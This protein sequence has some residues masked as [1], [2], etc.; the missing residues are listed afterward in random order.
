MTLSQYKNKKLK[1]LRKKFRTFTGE[2][3]GRSVINYLNRTDRLADDA[4]ERLIGL[5]QRLRSGED[6]RDDMVT[7]IGDTVRD[8]PRFW[9][10][11]VASRTPEGTVTVIDQPV[12]DGP[13]HPMLAMQLLEWNRCLVL[14]KR[15]MLDRI[16]RCAKPDCRKLF[17]ARFSHSQ[18]HSEACR[19][20]VEAEN[21]DYKERRREYM[22]E[23]REAEKVER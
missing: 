11:P 7:L 21:P 19:L 22:R 23:Q 4:V 9:T 6:T 13:I 5:M 3:L 20:A 2:A 16:R 15:N 17:W 10:M 1:K 8:T 14:L 18:Y 12:L